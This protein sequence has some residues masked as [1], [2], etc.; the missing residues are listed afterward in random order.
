MYEGCRD[1]ILGWRSGQRLQGAFAN[2]SSYHSDDCLQHV[3]RDKYDIRLFHLKG[4]RNVRIQQVRRRERLDDGLTL[5]QWNGK[6]SNKLSCPL[7]VLNVTTA[8]RYEKAKGLDII[9]KIKDDERGGR[10]KVGIPLPQDTIA[11][12]LRSSDLT[13]SSRVSPFLLFLP[14]PDPTVRFHYAGS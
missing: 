2:M 7:P 13:L 4:K 10:A 12:C 3:E 11:P 1:H 5:Y 9:L 14:F 6:E 8:T